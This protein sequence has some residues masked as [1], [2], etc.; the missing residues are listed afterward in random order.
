MAVAAVGGRGA[1]A[2]GKV[3]E[4][5]VGCGSADAAEVVVAGGGEHV[6]L[7]L[8]AAGVGA[9]LD[10]FHQVFVDAHGDVV[11]VRVVVAE[12]GGVVADV[13]AHDLLCLPVVLAG[14]E[15]FVHGV[16]FVLEDVLLQGGEA[17]GDGAEAGA[18]DV[19]GV[20][21]RAAAVVILALVD[22]ILDIQAQ[23]G[24]CSC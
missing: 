10:G 4:T 1:V 21:P 24:R 3:G 20:V 8:A 23:E 12:E 6:Q 11:G 15:D 19:G 2:D 7:C 22:A 16:A 14:G 9:S 13:L 17:V 18:L 5:A